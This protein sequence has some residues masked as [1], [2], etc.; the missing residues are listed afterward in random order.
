MWVEVPG[1]KGAPRAFYETL[2]E[3]LR[4]E[5]GFGDDDEVMSK[6]GEGPMAEGMEAD[7]IFGQIRERNLSCPTG[8]SGKSGNGE[9]RGGPKRFETATGE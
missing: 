7:R 6:R 3:W 1:T 9:S 5:M 4:E 8:F 2:N